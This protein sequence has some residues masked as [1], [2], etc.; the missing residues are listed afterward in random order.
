M[1]SQNRGNAPDKKASIL[2]LDRYSNVNVKQG[3]MR[4][5]LAIVTGEFVVAEV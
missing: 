2:F 5:P 1:V 4:W 3:C